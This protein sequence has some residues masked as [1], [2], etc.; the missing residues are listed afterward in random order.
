MHA[1]RVTGRMVSNLVGRLRVC[2]RTGGQAD[3]WA[4]NQKGPKVS[5]QAEKAVR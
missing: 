3:R 2:G 5:H 4:G 1:D